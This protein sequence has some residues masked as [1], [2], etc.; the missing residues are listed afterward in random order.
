VKGEGLFERKFYTYAIVRII[1]YICVGMEER[2]RGAAVE[3]NV[4]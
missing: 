2:G 1:N 4:N 3:E